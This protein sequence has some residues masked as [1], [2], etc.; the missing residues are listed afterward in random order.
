M[1]QPSNLQIQKRRT[2]DI[3]AQ[4]ATPEGV[5]DRPETSGILAEL[6]CGLTV[7]VDVGFGVTKA[8]THTG[9]MI[10]IPSVYGPAREFA[11][12]AEKIAEK[13]P[14]C[15]L[16]DDDGT[17]FMG[18]L[19][20]SQIPTDQIIRL[21]ARSSNE[22]GNNFRLR[23]FK[24]ALAA[25][26]PG[27]KGD[28]IHIRVATGLPVSHMPDA[29]TLKQ[30]VLGQHHIKTDQ[31]QF[32]ANVTEVMVMPQP[33]RTIY[34]MMLNPDGSLNAA[35]TSKKTG[36]I[37]IG[38][39][40]I[41]WAVDA[42]GEYIAA[43][44]GS[45]EAGV[46]TVKQRISDMLE[47]RYGQKFSAKEVEHVLLNKWLRISGE[48]VRFDSEVDQ[49]I[50]D[51]QTS[52]LAKTGELWKEARSNDV[53]WVAGGGTPLIYTPLVATYKQTKGAPA[54]QISNAQGYCK[55][56]LFVMTK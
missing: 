53:I 48:V 30:A 36:V 5:E 7:G 22:F 8:V 2:D 31:T 45:I 10:M 46:Y 27:L 21:R 41:D 13:Y 40:S 43:E 35:Y 39:Y 28:V 29:A 26:L 23:M 32:I 14:G 50:D 15:Q 11:F 56:A 19:A 9:R 25:L 18:H 34:N 4:P 47:K 33:Y 49:Y 16:A 52:V 37:D 17:W 12:Q 20:L 24:A 44:S 55:Y 3:P 38:E 51:L 42:D 54:P 6:I 1:A